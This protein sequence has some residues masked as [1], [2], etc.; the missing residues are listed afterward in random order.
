[1]VRGRLK[2]I[3]LVGAIS[4]TMQTTAWAGALPA[5]VATS[6]MAATAGRSRGRAGTTAQ[7]TGSPEVAPVGASVTRRLAATAAVSSESSGKVAAP[8]AARVVDASASAA[9]VAGTGAAVA[10]GSASVDITGT[11]DAP[12]LQAITAAGGSV[13]GAYPR[14]DGA[15]AVVPLAAVRGLAGRADVRRV[16]AAEH[17]LLHRAT[18]PTAQSG[19]VADE[20]DLTHGA[21]A[22]RTAFAVDGAGVKIGVLSDGIDGYAAHVPDAGPVTVLANQAGAGS[23]G[24]AMIEL[25]HDLAPGAGLWFATADGGQAAMA[26]NILDLQSAGCTIIVDDVT[27]LSE[28]AFQDGPISRAISSVRAAGVLFFSSAGNDGNKQ[29]GT[30]STWEGDFFPG[31][32]YNLGS[33]N[34]GD[35][36]DFGLATRAGRSISLD[37]ISFGPNPTSVQLQWADPIGASANDYDLVVTDP[38]GQV[39]DASNGVQSGNGV[40]YEE[41]ALPPTAAF[42]AVFRKRGAA[43]R[44][45]RVHVA[46]GSLD[47]F[48]TSGNVWGHNASSDAI[49]VGATP[50]A[51]AEGPG[52]P[53]GPYPALFSASSREELF[54]SDGPRRMFFTPTGVA[55]TPGNLTSTGGLTLQKPELVAADGVHT[56]VTTPAGYSPF[57]GTSAAAPHA[58]AI[59]ALLRQK[60]PTAGLRALTQALAAS[61]IDIDAPGVD[62]P[63]GVGIVMP[64]TA[65]QWMADH[66]EDAADIVPVVPERLLDTRPNTGDVGYQ[67]PKPAAGQTIELTVVNAGVTKVPA[68]ASAV[69]LN[70]TGA[71][72]GADGYVTV[73]PCGAP[74]PTASNLNLRAGDTRPNLAVSKIGTGGRVCLYTLSS[75]HLLADVTG[76]APAV[77]HL[78]SIVPARVLDTRPADLIGYQG[79][80]PVA[81]ETVELKVTGPATGVPDDASSVV[82]NVTATAGSAPGYV[83]VFP[84]GSP[85]PTASNVNIAPGITTPN[86]VIAKVGIG[87]KVCLFTSAATHLLGDLSAYVPATTS[88]RPVVPVRLL[89]TR[90]GSSQLGYLGPRPGVGQVVVLQLRGLGQPIVPP[91]AR[92]VVLNVTGVDAVGS[93]VTVWPCGSPRP[94]A[95]NLNLVAGD[96]RPNL[97]VT[98]LGT[99]DTVC[100]YTDQPANLIADLAGY[101][102]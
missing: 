60:H 18:A 45:V 90:P 85:R 31:Q 43:A 64:G 69:M 38:A 56:S 8:L 52:S 37:A 94:L 10:W 95:S 24:L 70:V 27:Y 59:A 12:L 36:L 54:T 25:I 71:S 5:H 30:S 74:R 44:F 9:A 29:D 61:A 11:I 20:A 92:A 49:T 68:D 13:V 72:A 17:P 101:Q 3:A 26:Q 93:Y 28:P 96:A 21:L 102:G 39:L 88:Y 46:A 65:L 98:K 32:A 42:V 66:P 99:G 48:S 16:Q 84:C 83:T 41:V 33:G 63:T 91:L 34:P 86:L 73:W 1:M 100:L 58:A 75:T 53:V 14:F 78:V 97:V 67:G 82:L 19:N 22:A 77:S 80:Q 81:N 55:L 79:T 51:R 87:G 7:T 57:F 50:A 6:A 23:E 89:D 62:A 47:T 4:L 40:A 76:Y 15:R 2:P 35:L